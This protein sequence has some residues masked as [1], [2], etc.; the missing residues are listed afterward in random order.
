V[1]REDIIAPF[2]GALACTDA[3]ELCVLPYHHQAVYVIDVDTC[4]LVAT[5]KVPAAAQERA[6]AAQERAAAVSGVEQVLTHGSSVFGVSAAG[7]V[8]VWPRS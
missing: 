8:F 3:R 6:A 1:C 2:A 5:L 4:G 7:A